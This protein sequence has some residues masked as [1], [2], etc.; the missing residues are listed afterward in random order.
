MFDTGLVSAPF[1]P[2]PDYPA[3]PTLH[4]W[5]RPDGSPP[6]GPFLAPRHPAVRVR[7]DDGRW[8]PAEVLRWYK[9]RHIF[10]WQ[11]LWYAQLRLPADTLGQA[12]VTWYA[13][14]PPHIQPR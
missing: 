13:Y 10:T 6:P 7:H 8:R 2:E 4:P 12:R 3:M 5:Q 14:D 1:Q 9:G 11:P